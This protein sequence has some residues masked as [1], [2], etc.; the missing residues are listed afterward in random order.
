MG[1]GLD[2]AKDRRRWWLWPTV[3]VLVWLF[4]G[5]PLGAFAGKLSEVQTNDNAAFLPASAESTEVMEWQARFSDQE[6]MP[7]VVV[8]ENTDGLDRAAIPAVQADLRAIADI[9]GV[10]QVSPPI[11]SEDG[12]AVQAVVAVDATIGDEIGTVVDQMRAQLSD[13]EVGGQ[14]YVTGP[15]GVLADFVEAFGAID[16]LLLVVALCVVLLILLV[17][18][19]SPILPLLVL[20]SSLLA[21]GVAS[22]VVYVLADNDLLDLNGQSQGILFV[23]VVGA[24]TDYALLLVSRFREELREHASRVVAM[25]RAYRGVV[26]P[27][28]ASGFTVILGLL[29]LLLSDLSSNQGLGPVGALG[30]AGA[31]LSAL[32]FLPAALVLLGRG[33]YWPFRPALGSEHPEVRGV[34]GKVAGLVGRRPRATWVLT[35]VGLAVA[36]A[37]LP[38]FDDEGT[39]Q[40]EVFLTEVDSVQ[41]Q[42]ALARHFEADIGTP[43]VILGPAGRLPQILDAVGSSDD[44]ASAAPVTTAPAGSQGRSPGQPPGQPRVVDGRV[45]VE[46]SLSEG[47]DNDASTRTRPST[48][49]G[50]P[51]GCSGDRPC[52]PAGAV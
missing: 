13:S 35:F 17:V 1:S 10:L 47:T 16:G 34:W 8:Y 43:I 50:R 48:A 52:D 51:G 44:V 45:L 25:R 7:A 9:D 18:Y 38:T 37:F 26:E 6:V 11:P 3:L 46:A 32:T 24:S 4:V 14:V 28:A 31:M 5:A 36:A 22:A 23:L 20:F 15:A 21:L 27:I 30:I 49:R 19:R 29:C 40:S 42:E 2:T 12:A 41:G 33:A 39:A